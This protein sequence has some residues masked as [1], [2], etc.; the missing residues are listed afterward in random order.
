[1]VK[2][3]TVCTKTLRDL[4]SH[5]GFANNSSSD[6]SHDFYVLQSP[7]NKMGKFSLFLP[8]CLGSS[9]A[10]VFKTGPDS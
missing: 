10:N 1:M 6:D 4:Y 2:I 9:Y 3:S 7:M 5:S 8:L